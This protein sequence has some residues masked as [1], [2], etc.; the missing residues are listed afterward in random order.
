M[1]ILFLYDFPLWGNGSAHFMRHLISELVKFGHEVAVVT[2]DKRRLQ[3]NVRTFTVPWQET[4]VFVAHPE[5]PKARPYAKLNSVD[6]AGL[7][8]AYLHTAIRAYKEFKPDVVHV[9]HLF[10]ITWAARYLKAILK[11]KYIITVHGSD[12]HALAN[13][14]R[15]QLMTGDAVKGAM[16]ITPVSG[17]TR[18]WFTQL[19]GPG[20]DYKLRTQPGG[21]DVNLFPKRLDTSMIERRYKLK[22]KKVVMFAG[23]LTPQKGTQYL[24]R[25]TRKIKGEVFI[26]GDGSERKKLEKLARELKLNNIHFLGYFGRRHTRELKEFYYR[27]DVFVAPSVWEEPLGLV[28]LEAMICETPV[29]VTRKGGIPLAVKDKVNGLFVRARNSEDIA[30]KVNY[31]LENPEMSAK[32][33]RVARQIVLEKFNWATIAKR[34][35]RMYQE[36]VPPTNGNIK[37]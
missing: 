6:I 28:I 37:K 16:M 20:F 2:P 29:V 1:R 24:V 35:E 31:L 22:G 30:K 14:R 18:A 27:S 23:R 36:M 10:L 19:F 17:D 21:V 8:C 5:L 15:Y 33:G 9:N 34:F 32:M 12:L 4:P 25:A 26:V 3:K 11:A 7:H 13:D